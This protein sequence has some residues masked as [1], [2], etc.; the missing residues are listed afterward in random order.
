MMNESSLYKNSIQIIAMGASTGGTEALL[1]ILEKLP[2]NLP[3]I[4]ITQHMPP[5]FTNM[6]A[7]RLNRICKMEVREAKDQDSLY[8]GLCLIAPGGL[9]MQVVKDREGLK[10]SC[11]EGEKVSGHCPSIDYLFSSVAEE[12]G[13]HA[14]G[15]LLTG[16]GR[17]GAH[18]LLLMHEK[19]AYTLGQDE[20][21]SVVYGMPM[22]AYKLGA[23][24]KQ[25]N[26]S[27]IANYLLDCFRMG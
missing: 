4:V 1:A 11:L 25:G 24:D 9:Q 21:S 14:V 17:D 7:E 12:C 27:Q 2:G 22:E 10:V 16:M 8:P 5:I 23:V 18:G 15:I 20:E 6:Y 19:G 13:E 3:P 26:L